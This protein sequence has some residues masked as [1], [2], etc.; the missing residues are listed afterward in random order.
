MNLFL[1]NIT[2]I[3]SQFIKRQKRYSLSYHFQIKR[4]DKKKLNMRINLVILILLSVFMQVS[5]KSLGQE[6]SINKQNTRIQE[7]FEEIK[8]QTGYGYIFTNE[9]FKRNKISIRAQDASINEVLDE[10]LKGLP[11]AY[12]IVDKNI[13]IKEKRTAKND[14]TSNISSTHIQNQVRGNVKDEKGEPLAGVSIKLKNSNVGVTTDIDGNFL[15]QLP[16]ENET[17]IFSFI[18]FL[19]QEIPV[20]N[21]SIINVQL[22]SEITDLSEVV[23]VGYGTQR[24]SDLT[25]AVNRVTADQ[26]SDRPASNVGQALQGKVSGVEIVQQGGGIPGGAPM[27]RVR[28]INSINT[29]NDPLFVVDG[30]VGVN[31]ALTSL[32]PNEI[33]AID[34]LKD[35]SATAIYG[36]R[37]SNGVIVITTKR[38][39]SGKTIV[40]YSG[41]ASLGVMNRNFYALNADELMYVYEQSM[42]NLEKYAQGKVIN[43]SKDFRG[44][45][46]SGLSYS[47]MSWLFQKTNPNDY[48]LDLIGKDGNYYAPRFNT[49]WEDEI[50]GNAFSSNHHIDVSGGNEN[51]RFSVST[52]YT[53]DNGLM[54]DSYY[55]RFNGRVTGDIKVAEWLDLSTQIGFLKSKNSEDDRSIT[56]TAVETWSILPIKYPNDPDIYGIYAGRWGSNSNF[57]VGEEWFNPLF[58]RS[59]EKGEFNNSQVTGNIIAN[60]SILENLSLTSNVSFDLN[61]SKYNSYRGKLY[62]REGE[63]RINTG[64]NFYWQSETYLNYNKRFSDKHNL[65]AMIGMSWSRLKWEDFS[66]ISK[67]FFDN[68]YQWH[69]LSVGSSRPTITS[70]D[71]TSSLNSYFSRLNYNYDNKYLV[72]VTGRFDGSS[73]FGKNHK[74]GFFPSLGLAWRISEENFM[75]DNSSISDLKIRASVGQTGNQEI[76]SYVTQSYLGST[77]VVLG[78]NIYTGL[79][80]NSVGNPD[81]KWETSTQYDVGVELSLFNNRVTLEADY[82]HKTTTDMLLDVP[83][84]RSTTTGSVK[85]NYGS[86]ENQGVELAIQTR[87]I[88]SELFSWNTNVVFATNKNKIVKLGPTGSDIFFQTGAGNGTRVLRVGEPI[89]SFF[90]LNRLGTYSTEEV[91][92]AAQYGM[93]PGDLKF[94]DK[95]NDGKINLIADGDIIGRSFP[96]WTMGIQNSFKYKNFDASI[97]IRIVYGLDKASINESAEDRQLVS[98][99]KNSVL[100][101]WRPDHQNAMIAQVRPGSAGG[102]YQSY[103][104]THMI[105]DASFIRGQNATLGYSFSSLNANFLGIKKARV[106]LNAQ[107]FFLRTK[108]TGYDPEGSS[109]DQMDPLA[110][111]IDKYLY[112][113]PTTLSLGVNLSL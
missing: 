70:G 38:G 21:R 106:Y 16:S 71:G 79:F 54:K 75:K 81:L 34:V 95:D 107:N 32:D 6:I 20:N 99:G 100:N 36:A 4:M 22:E 27:V 9:S 45:Y 77:G 82:Y 97:D 92:L 111:G 83:L 73:K 84:P 18:G 53:D 103:P 55:K 68:Y 47:E 57:N 65:I 64:N 69:N 14:N 11:F 46:A 98:G 78:G 86:I 3:K 26:I 31:N 51:N 44:P 56:R 2:E 66:G 42:A 109:L 13:L 80:P 72:T 29:S 67:N 17:L 62:G 24:K 33:E 12:S 74:Y 7:V 105:E 104:D 88:S 63:A 108:V 43:R 59:E 76:G 37:G 35:A 19:P 89:G 15:I 50:Y 102:Y 5:A 101:A 1:F 40:N 90:G 85:R 28:G 49:N 48:V 60:A 87:N 96:K 61:N 52:A 30:I 94:E 112:P 10:C 39:K 41:S 93:L 91:S 25:G 8:K 58:L 113:R 23:V 110:T